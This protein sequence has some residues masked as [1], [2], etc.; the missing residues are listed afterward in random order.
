MKYRL[1]DMT[2][3]W[4]KISHDQYEKNN[5]KRFNFWCALLMYI[6]FV[7]SIF[8][9]QQGNMLFAALRTTSSTYGRPI[10]SFSNLPLH[11]G[12]EMTTGKQSKVF[13]SLQLFPYFKPPPPP[14]PP[15]FSLFK[16]IIYGGGGGGHS[17]VNPSFYPWVW[18]AIVQFLIMSFRMAVS[19]FKEYLWHLDICGPGLPLKNPQPN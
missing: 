1:N 2:Y 6:F 14:P 19:L 7:F 16:I 11:A 10:M 5:F 18:V 13:P 3:A 4:Q 9:V 17:H 8:T 12:I 15:K